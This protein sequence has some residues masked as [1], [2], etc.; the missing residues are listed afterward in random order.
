M[1]IPGTSSG[2]KT[3]AISHRRPQIKKKATVVTAS[4]N[5]HAGGNAA[6][7]ESATTARAR[8]A[9]DLKTLDFPNPRAL[10]AGALQLWSLFREED[11][12]SSAPKTSTGT[13]TAAADCFFKSGPFDEAAVVMAS[14]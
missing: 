1:F 11:E 14:L 10:D 12:D 13:S 5:S 2:S 3:T 4:M 7:S 8:L 6:S 9:I